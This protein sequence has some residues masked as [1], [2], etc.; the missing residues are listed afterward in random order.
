MRS[1][2][3]PPLRRAKAK[4]KIVAKKPRKKKSERYEEALIE[5]ASYVDDDDWIIIKKQLLRVLAADLR[6]GFTTR[7][8]V[9]KRHGPMNRFEKNLA[10]IWERITERLVIFTPDE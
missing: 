6:T 4:K 3:M 1:G 10:S 5:V 8:P 7:D 2:F 9:T